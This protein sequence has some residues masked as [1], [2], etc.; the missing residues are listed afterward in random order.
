MTN[1]IVCV[2]AGHSNTDSGAVAKD[3]TQENHLAVK[4]RNA[5]VSYLQK[6]SDITVRT[7]GHGNNNAP[8]AEAIKL[9]KGSDLALECHM[10]A[11][12][13]P[14]ASGVESISLPKQKAISQNISASIAKVFESK[15]RGDKGWISQEQSARGKL[16]FVNAG[17]IIVE[18]EYISNPEKLQ[19]F[20]DTYWL[21]AKAV[22][23]EICK[24][25]KVQP[26]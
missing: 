9:V 1:K 17:G 13:N 18:L 4:F 21:A 20:N 16:G 5:V 15:L 10:N 8:L 11:F 7:D 26:M 25:L 24:Y 2:T 3:G 14:T 23:L 19:K 12:T 6:H 22:Y